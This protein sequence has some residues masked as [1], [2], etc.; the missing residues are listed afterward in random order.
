MVAERDHSSVQI[1]LGEI[2][3]H[4]NSKDVI[5]CEYPKNIMSGKTRDCIPIS[6]EIEKL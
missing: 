3:Y 4:I 1:T 2:K 6:Q 5:D